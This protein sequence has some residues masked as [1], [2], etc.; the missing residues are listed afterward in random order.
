MTETSNLRHRLEQLYNSW[1]ETVWEGTEVRLSRLFLYGRWS[2]TQGDD[3]HKLQS[4][5]AFWEAVGKLSGEYCDIQQFLSGHVRV[6]LFLKSKHFRNHRVPSCMEPYNHIVCPYINCA[7]LHEFVSL[8]FFDFVNTNSKVASEQQSYYSKALPKRCQIREMWNYTE[9]KLITGKMRDTFLVNTCCLLCGLFPYC[10]QY[11]VPFDG[12]VLVV[13]KLVYAQTAPVLESVKQLLS[14]MCKCDREAKQA[15]FLLHSIRLAFVYMLEQLPAIKHILMTNS[16]FTKYLRQIQTHTLQVHVLSAQNFW[17]SNGS[18][19]LQ[20]PTQYHEFY[21]SPVY[22]R[23]KRHLKQFHSTHQIPVKDINMAHA[24][25]KVDAQRVAS[26]M[27]I[28]Q[29]KAGFEVKDCVQWVRQIFDLL[30]TSHTDAG[31]EDCLMHVYELSVNDFLYFEQLVYLWCEFETSKVYPLN[32]Q[33]RQ[34]QLQTVVDKWGPN[35]SVQEACVYICFGCGE[36]KTSVCELHVPC[37]SQKHR[38]PLASCKVSVELTDDELHLFCNRYMG[39]DKLKKSS[40]TQT[41]DSAIHETWCSHLR[42]KQVPIVGHILLHANEMYTLCPCCATVMK[43]VPPLPPCC[44]WCKIEQR[45]RLLARKCPICTHKQT[46]DDTRCYFVKATTGK[47]LRQRCCNSCYHS[48]VV[49]SKKPINL[50]TELQK[51]LAKL[52]HN[53]ALRPVQ[54]RKHAAYVH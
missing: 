36:I 19:V 22:T 51:D 33:L 12:L 1:S 38:P 13:G 4:R 39:N 35:R 41:L 17:G 2:E 18:C 34:Q 20:N 50:L 53:R 37:R 52:E 46:A 14:T 47:V 6:Y 54:K 11:F 30:L 29:L 23:I 9:K 28:E 32:S 43:F 44:Q 26:P 45:Q 40:K 8:S 15:L 16:E 48:V 25:R 24:A 5:V 3:L 49:P 31:V 10:D 7:A 42:L 21:H 27:A